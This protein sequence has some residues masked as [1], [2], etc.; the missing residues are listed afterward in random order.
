MYPYEVLER[1]ESIY[2][3]AVIAR[4]REEGI[5]VDA[6]SEPSSTRSRGVRGKAKEQQKRKQALA[7]IPELREGWDGCH[8]KYRE[9]T[10]CFIR[11]VIVGGMVAQR[12]A[13]GLPP[14]SS[15]SE[16][17]E[18]QDLLDPDEGE[19]SVRH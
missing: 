17:Y 14:A 9:N 2:P 4:L 16:A 13:R 18:M 5:E 12:V 8:I 11:D 6:V 3:E 10:Y 1:A 7:S 15:A 19:L